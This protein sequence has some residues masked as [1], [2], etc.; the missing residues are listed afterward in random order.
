MKSLV[1]LCSPVTEKPKS[2]EFTPIP[3]QATISPELAVRIANQIFPDGDIH[4]MFLP[5]EENGVYKILKHEGDKILFPSRQ[6]MLVIDAYNG[7]PLYRSGQTEPTAGDIFIEWQLA[8]HSGEA[9][10]LTG[11]IVVLIA[12][13]I[14]PLLYVTGVIRWLQKHRVKRIGG[15]CH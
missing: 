3:G 13:L 6:K 1:T 14:P 5:L 2:F 7:K 8:L 11:K 10:G 9:F 4:A 15:R 12:G